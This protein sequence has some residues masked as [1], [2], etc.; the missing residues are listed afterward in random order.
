MHFTKSFLVGASISTTFAAVH[1][2][3]VGQNGGLTFEPI[4]VQAAVGD[5]VIYTFMTQVSERG[6]VLRNHC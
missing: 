1:N 2:V 3:A 6:T 4:S 5:S